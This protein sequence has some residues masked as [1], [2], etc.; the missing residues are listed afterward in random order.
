MSSHFF[1]SFE[2]EVSSM[3]LPDHFPDPYSSTINPLC[4]EATQLLQKDLE[5]RNWTHNFGLSHQ[6]EAFYTGKM[7]GVLVVVDP[8]E[9]I[10][11]L[12][13]FSGKLGESNHHE[14]F[15]P[16]VYDVLDKE[17]FLHAGMLELTGINETISE[18][19]KD[20]SD[21][22]K[23][24]IDQ[25][26]MKRKTLSIALQD[27]ISDQ[28]HFLNGNQ[29]TK[30]LREIFLKY[31][32]KNAPGGAGECAAPKLLQFAFQHQLKPI[33]LTEFYWG[34]SI[35]SDQWQNL[36]HYPPCE[37]KCRP[38]LSHMLQGIV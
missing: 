1:R 17:G 9:Q 28:Y 30:S 16:P 12:A 10:G 38:I 37:S 31:T 18:L 32:Q 21:L 26:K 4:L 7:F 25:L 8:L 2:R 20:H 24:K 11:F 36:Q 3:E 6:I 29:E 14:G 19:A 34:R 13:A 33:S 27:R 35:H 23:Q 22:T 5:Q 15:V